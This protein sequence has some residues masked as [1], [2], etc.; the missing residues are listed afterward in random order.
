M[1]LEPKYLGFVVYLKSVG[2][3]PFSRTIYSNDDD[4]DGDDNDYSYN[5]S[6][7]N[8]RLLIVITTGLY[9]PT[10]VCS[11]LL[12]GFPTHAGNYSPF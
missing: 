7:N 8:N 2:P 5:N 9:N 1:G 10:I 3:T 6:N 12:R 4:Y 11:H